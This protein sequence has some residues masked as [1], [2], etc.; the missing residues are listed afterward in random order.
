VPGLSTIPFFGALFRS[1]SLSKVKTELVVVVKASLVNASM[2]P[3]V[4]PTDLT[5]S[6]D[7]VDIL[8]GGKLEGLPKTVDQKITD[9]NM[10]NDLNNKNIPSAAASQEN[11]ATKDKPTNLIDLLR[12]K[13]KGNE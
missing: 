7:N 6:P 5:Q 2:K 13:S 1:T 4:L 10:M 12:K 11:I 9:T 8:I 3:P